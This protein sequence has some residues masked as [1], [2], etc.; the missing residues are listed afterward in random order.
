MKQLAGPNKSKLR[1]G[2]LVKL[3]CKPQFSQ[4]GDL[5]RIIR[6]VR[7]SLL[8]QDLSEEIPLGSNISINISLFATLLLESLKLFKSSKLIN[9]HFINYFSLELLEILG[10]VYTFRQDISEKIPLRSNVNISIPLFYFLTSLS[11]KLFKS[12]KLI[13][14]HFIN[15]SDLTRIIRYLG[16]SLLIYGLSEEILFGSKVN[17]FTFLSHYF[18]KV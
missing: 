11:L 2:F 17:I 8:I 9:Y 15:Y 6:N 7:R 12:S 14:H 5:T 16:R 4:D 1:S 18:L 13:N 10:E 3:A